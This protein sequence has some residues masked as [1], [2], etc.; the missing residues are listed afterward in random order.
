MWQHTDRFTAVAD[1][2]GRYVLYED[3]EI[4][5]TS[6]TEEDSITARTKRYRTANGT[7]ASVVGPGLFR[8]FP[9]G[10]TV[11]KT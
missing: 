3:T 9:N 4:V 6:S 11:R 1:D 5:D 10:P 8:L 2:G 7:P